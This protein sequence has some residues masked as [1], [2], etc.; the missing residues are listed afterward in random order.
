MLLIIVVFSG[1][2]GKIPIPTLAAILI[3]AAASSLRLA[4]IDTILRTG[5][6][7]QIG[8]ITTLVATL[9]L[10]VT[11]AVGIGAALS[12]LM[13]VNQEAVDLKVVRLR[14]D[15]D[16][17]LVE[18]RSPE[19]T[20][21]GEVMLLDVYGSLMLAGARTLQARLP[22]PPEQHGPRCAPLRGR[23]TLGATAFIVIADYAERIRDAGGHLFLSG[24]DPQ[25]LNQLQKA[26]RVDLE[27]HRY[28]PCG[29]RA[30]CSHRPGRLTRTR[31]A[32]LVAHP[33][34]HP[35]GGES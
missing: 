18:E 20:P 29:H 34:P 26:H 16:G 15:G 19:T 25:L 31:E 4:R 35:T 33:T 5:R 24:V 28:C 3:F 9:L 21:D 11:A 32:W 8:F 23:T 27:E 10:P 22:T 7:S 17:N 14:P 13:Q 2:V 12:L 1:V 6:T 30:P